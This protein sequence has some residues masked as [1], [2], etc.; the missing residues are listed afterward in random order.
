MSRITR[1]LCY[2]LNLKLASVLSY[3]AFPSLTILNTYSGICGGLIF[4]PSRCHF[5]STL[6]ANYDHFLYASTA[7]NCLPWSIMSA[8]PGKLLD[9]CTSG[10]YLKS[11]TVSDSIFKILRRQCCLIPGAGSPSCLKKEDFSYSL[12]YYSLPASLST[13]YILAIVYL[14]STCFPYHPQICTVCVI[15]ASFIIHLK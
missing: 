8:E 10:R 3:Y 9:P 11:K 12:Y 4:L 14:L 2:F 6:T 7:F 15:S 1:F 5:F 13:Y